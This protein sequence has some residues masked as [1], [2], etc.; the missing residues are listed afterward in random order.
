[1]PDG[2]S[3]SGTQLNVHPRYPKFRKVEGDNCCRAH[4]AALLKVEYSMLTSVASYS[5]LQIAGLE[6]SELLYA[7][8]AND[9]HTKPYA[10][11]GERLSLHS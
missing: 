3:L 9:V 8:F 6:A 1:V 7:S 10:I 2:D 4:E 11:I 5:I